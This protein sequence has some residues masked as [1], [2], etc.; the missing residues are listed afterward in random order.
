MSSS[1][2]MEGRIC[3]VYLDPMIYEEQVQEETQAVLEG[4]AKDR[5]I[6]GIVVSFEKVEKLASGGLGLMVV[7][8]KQL[9]DRKAKFG[10]CSLHPWH[11]HLFQMTKLD[12]FLTMY[13]S[14]EAALAAM[15][16]AK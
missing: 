2:R 15:V 10:I 9:H 8:Y 12:G 14:E 11:R 1:H 4:L 5:S 6:D 13:A 7:T 16:S 3:I